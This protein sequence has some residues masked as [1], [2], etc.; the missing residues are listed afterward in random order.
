MSWV[1]ENKFL[2]G[3]GAVLAV[4]LGTLGYLT[5]SAMDKYDEASGAFAT[6]SSQLKTFQQAKP[7]LNDANLKEL[8]AQ[9]QE[10]TGK[11]GAFQ[12]ELKS[13]VLPI[14]PMEKAAFQDKLKETVARVSTKAADANVGRPKDFYLGFGEYQSKPPDDK[15]TAAL[16]RELA[17]IELLMDVL[18]KTGGVEI[19]EFHR[20][21]IP[22]EGRKPDEA[23]GGDGKRRSSADRSDYGM[24]ERNSLRLKLTCT[25]DAFRKIL[26]ELANHRQQLFVIRNVTLLNTQMDSPPRLSTLA[27]TANPGGP[28]PPVA[29]VPM[30]NE[31]PLAYVFGTEKI[32][33]VIELDVLNIEEAKQK[34]EKSGKTKEK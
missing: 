10:L 16:A 34:P 18:I 30:V 2:T 3:F 31:A 9:K 7:S 24:V 17:A 1:S 26:N 25:D 22:E 19:G 15:A 33:G 4:G 14:A 8:L 20:D 6:A 13:R 23:P 12:T 29:L 28:I 5:Y 27:P 11:I 21:P 32:V